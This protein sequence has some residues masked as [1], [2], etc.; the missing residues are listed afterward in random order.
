MSKKLVEREYL[1]HL[2]TELFFIKLQA[3]GHLQERIENLMKFIEDNIIQEDLESRNE[4]K[5]VVYRKMKEAKTP[6]ENQQW[7]E[8]YKSLDDGNIY[9]EPKELFT[10]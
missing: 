5:R 4:I 7:Y 9:P 6:E 8:Y 3:S 2:A 1:N 10:E